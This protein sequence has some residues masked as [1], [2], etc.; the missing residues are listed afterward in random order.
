VS[1]ERSRVRNL[2]AKKDHATFGPRAHQQEKL[3]LYG[4]KG[5]VDDRQKN[6][7]SPTNLEKILVS[8]LSS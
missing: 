3:M 8:K 5:Q 1:P 2:L 7:F 4:Y 6:F